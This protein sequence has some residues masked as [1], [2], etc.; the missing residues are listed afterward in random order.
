VAPPPTPTISF[1]VA[2]DPEGPW[3]KV[4]ANASSNF[5]TGALI[6]PM[7]H[8]NGTVYVVTGGHTILRAYDWRGP[9]EYVASG[10]CGGGEDNFIYIDTR[11]NWH[12]LY[13]RAP[14]PDPAA[15]GGHAFSR[16]GLV[17]HVSEGAAYPGQQAYMGGHVGKYGKRER[18]HLV[19][20]AATGEP[21]HLTNGVCLNSNWMECNNNPWPGYFDYTFTTVAPIQ[22][23]SV[24][25]RSMSAQDAY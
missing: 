10:A 9:Y 13:H 18:P 16:D 7:V 11:G 25:H 6:T 17:W 23:S 22:R 24:K 12:C 15:Q 3:R 5:G 14:F 19:F 20:D 21:T 2:T 1:H 8:P 4:T